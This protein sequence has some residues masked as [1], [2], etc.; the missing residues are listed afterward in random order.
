MKEKRCRLPWPASCLPRPSPSHPLQTYGA[1]DPALY[2]VSEAIPKLGSRLQAS[3][4]A[5][6]ASSMA[7]GRH[8]C[9]VYSTAAAAR[10][11]A[12]DPSPALA[13]PGVLEFVGPADIPG[14]NALCSPAEPLFFATGAAPR[15]CLVIRQSRS[16]GGR[17][18]A[19]TSCPPPPSPSPPNNHHALHK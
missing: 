14:V 4:E 7:S 3:G 13:L 11:L 9:L 19:S 10:L 8:G 1:G 17:V 6:Y 5:A 12:L 18:A 15:G 16:F 2:P